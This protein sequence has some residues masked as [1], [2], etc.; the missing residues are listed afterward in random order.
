MFGVYCFAGLFYANLASTCVLTLLLKWRGKLDGIVNDNH[1]HDL[2][3]FMF[4]F[5][6]FWAYIGFSQFM[7]IWYAN[8][9]EET[10]YF[11]LRLQGEWKWVSLFLVVGKFMLPF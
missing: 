7:L 8:L 2:G 4:A 5:T 9:P 6:V 1:L 3:K 11:L 10:G